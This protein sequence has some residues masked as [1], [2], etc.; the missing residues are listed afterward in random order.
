MRAACRPLA[1][2]G[3]CVQA[4]FMAASQEA[5]PSNRQRWWLE[6]GLLFATRGGRHGAQ[7]ALL[8]VLL[9]DLLDAAPRR[10]R[11]CLRRGSGLRVERDEMPFCILWDADPGPS[12]SHG[13]SDGPTL[14][15][16]ESPTPSSMPVWLAATR[17]LHRYS[18]GR[19]SPGVDAST[20]R[21]ALH[22]SCVMASRLDSSAISSQACKV[23]GKLH[24]G[25]SNTIEHQQAQCD[26]WSCCGT[27]LQQ[28]AGAAGGTPRTECLFTPWPGRQ[29]ARAR[30]AAR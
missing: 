4:A 17:P 12:S 6:H 25:A 7:V 16:I 5:Y 22:S 10:L 27:P 19:R 9:L 21:I 13:M 1:H 8:V 30:P 3:I 20:A 26:S 15:N 2:A 14:I 23:Q 18:A 28:L 24:D 29:R 11:Q